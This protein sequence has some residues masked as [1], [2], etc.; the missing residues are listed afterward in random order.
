[1][2]V[3]SVV[4]AALIGA[5]VGA[6]TGLIGGIV[7]AACRSFVLVSGRRA[8]TVAFAASATPFLLYALLIW[9]A[10]G[11]VFGF[12]VYSL[13]GL[14]AGGAGAVLAPWVVHGRES[15][16]STWS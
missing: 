4:A 12:G 14:F 9:T 16:R 3:F 13:A 7:L 10:T 1:V 2:I 15:R 11:S 6:V 8:R 5:G